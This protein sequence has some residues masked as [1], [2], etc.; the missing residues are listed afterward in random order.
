MP[1]ARPTVDDAEQRPNGHL[2]AQLEP[3]LQLFPSPCVHTDLAAPAA[4]ATADQQGATA[5]IEIGLSEGERF[6]DAQPGAPQ[7]HDEPAQPAAVRIVAGGAHHGDDFFY[8]RR[9]GRI[10]KTLV[11]RRATK[12]ES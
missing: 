9:I 8:L 5:V 7:D 10:A 4:L 2:Q 12:V 1:A 3:R 11:V 6:L